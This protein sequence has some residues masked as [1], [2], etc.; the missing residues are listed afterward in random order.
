MK[1]LLF[2]LC[3]LLTVGVV[4]NQ[5]I[6]QTGFGIRGGVNFANLNDIDGEVDSR[7]GFMAGLYFNFPV[8]N[9]PVS[10][11]PEV[12]YTQKG[13]ESGDDTFQLDYVEVP[14][15]AKFNFITNGNIT[16]N[17][18]F[19]PYVGFNVSAEVD[20]GNGD[21]LFGDDTET[22]IED[23]VENTDFG[24]TVGGGLDFGRFDLGVRYNAGLTEVF[25]DGL[26]DND[27]GAK[28][29]V[30]SITAGIDF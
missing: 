25:E 27:S 16:P 17:V 13:F 10:I 14:V 7:T 23:G 24:V 20:T 30:F 4:A 29:G 12:L 22:D 5:A 1:K 18:Y 28:H 19:G 21:G 8:T 3:L 15:L 11:Q 2:T 9:S 26:I 6:A